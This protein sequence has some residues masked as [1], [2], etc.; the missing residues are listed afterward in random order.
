MQNPSRL[1]RRTGAAVLVT[2]ALAAG[3][4]GSAGLPAGA[5]TGDTLPDAIV[6]GSVAVGADPALTGALG[7][8]QSR[9]AVDNSALKVNLQFVA[10][11]AGLARSG[12][13]DVIVGPA[14]SLDG[15][16]A[17]GVVD[18]P[19]PFARDELQIV[20]A[21]GNPRG[22][23]S[24]ADLARPGLRI[25][26]PAAEVSA[27]AVAARGLLRAVGANATPIAVANPAAAISAVNH[28]DLDATIVYA[29]EATDGGGDLTVSV[30]PE[31]DPGRVF[32]GAVVKT[33][34]Q[35][36]AASG[37]LAQ[38]VNGVGSQAVQGRG[39]RLP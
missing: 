31:Q 39:F 10:D 23:V 13:V 28:G 24:A 4:C 2:A 16:R 34:K 29:S 8:D 27:S 36:R 22:I 19:V 37:Y 30:T 1:V 20:V 17:A 33:T 11:P 15:L 12:R 21:P 32:A 26:L 5:P 6:A 3:G 9:L 38:L 25:A 7:D 14:E 18:E 35:R